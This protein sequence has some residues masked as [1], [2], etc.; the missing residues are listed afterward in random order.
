[1]P[2]SK[3]EQTDA[4]NTPLQRELARQILDHMHRA[5][6]KA[7]ERVRELALAKTFGVSRTPVRAA[8]EAL[9]KLGYVQL[10]PNRGFVLRRKVNGNRTPAAR[11]LRSSFDELRSQLLRDHARGAIP[12]EFS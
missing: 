7:G 6:L 10:T 11:A 3:P 5:S 2:R 12:V 9:E 8:L 4:G 1:M